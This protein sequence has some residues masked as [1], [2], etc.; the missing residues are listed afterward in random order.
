MVICE[1]LFSCRLLDDV[2]TGGGDTQGHGMVLVLH[3]VK[4]LKS[5]QK[6]SKLLTNQ[7]DSICSWLHC[8]QPFHKHLTVSNCVHHRK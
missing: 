2:E 8:L 4:Q 3:M 6:F 7:Y 5:F 1:M